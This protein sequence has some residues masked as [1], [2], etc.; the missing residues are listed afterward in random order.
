MRVFNNRILRIKESLEKAEA[1]TYMALRN[2]DEVRDGRLIRKHVQIA[3]SL[4]FAR[5]TKSELEKFRF[6]HPGEF[7][8][9]TK[10]ASPDPA[11]IDDEE[12]RVFMLVTS[13]GGGRGIEYLGETFDF[14]TGD[15]VR[16]IDGAYKGAEG[17]IRRVRRDR[18]L[19]VAVKGVAVVALSHIPFE[20]LE[21]V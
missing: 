17:V 16:V 13:V 20:Y 9:Y 18:K 15:K 6:A 8:V 11:P 10:A 4:L 12:M 21:K 19:L 14:K 1:Q 2:E 3:P 5:C 7:M